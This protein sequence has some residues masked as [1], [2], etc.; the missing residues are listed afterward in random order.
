MSH[1][2]LVRLRTLALAA[3]LLMLGAEPSNAFECLAEDGGSCASWPASSQPI[4]YVVNTEE[5]V[6]L[7]PARALQQAITGM[8]TWTE[9]CSACFES[10]FARETDEFALD[11]DGINTIEWVAFEWP[12]GEEVIGLTSLNW[13]SNESGVPVIVE[14]DM[15]LNDDF[16]EWMEL[17]ASNPAATEGEVDALSIIVHEA[18]HFYGLG[19]SS[20][21]NATMFP[22]YLPG[23]INPRS[24]AADDMAGISVLYSCEPG[25]DTC[26]GGDDDDDDAPPPDDGD[27]GGGS[28]AGG[29]CLQ[30]PS[31]PACQQQAERDLDFDNESS[32]GCTEIDRP[33]FPRGST[34]G[35]KWVWLA[36]Q[37]TGLLLTVGIILRM[38]R[39]QPAARKNR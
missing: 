27:G 28:N 17:A 24:L 20:D 19:H 18:G 4:P 37:L 31:A 36:F 10:R 38:R 21:A 14:S 15:F 34:T 30:N 13:V 26:G 1:A 23:D 32:C 3:P 2:A 5:S 16:Y 35:E 12:F 39:P 6:D 22:S 7:D 8:S 33:F 11:G 25:E 9:V 29:A